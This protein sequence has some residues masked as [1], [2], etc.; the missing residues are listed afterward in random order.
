MR[1]R[2]R[3]RPEEVRRDQLILDA[4][5]ARPLGS[6]LGGA[7]AGGTSR[8]GWHLDLNDGVR[9]NIRPFLAQDIPGGNRWND[10]HYGNAV[11]KAARVSTP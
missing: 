9:M 11:K 3:R 1:P 7:G 8:S 5:D 2:R 6:G 10:C 4:V